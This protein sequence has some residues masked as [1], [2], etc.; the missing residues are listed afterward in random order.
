MRRRGTGADRGAG[1]RITDHI[2]DLDHG[3]AP[4]PRRPGLNGL[5]PV[6]HVF[7]IVLSDRGF[8]QSFGASSG[9]L[10]GALRRQGE[11]VLN[12]YAVAGAPLANE[13]AL[14][15]GQ[16]PTVQTATD[17]PKFTRINHAGTR[18]PGDR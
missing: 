6:K 8:A 2:A 3:Y 14:V 13:I 15:S 5:P 16:G 4:V 12:Y 10:S 7:M 18:V 11:L 9:Y 17:C 1:V